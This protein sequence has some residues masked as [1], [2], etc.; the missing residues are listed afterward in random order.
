MPDGQ[1]VAQFAR[2]KVGRM[3]WLDGNA[4]LSTGDHM[5]LLKKDPVAYATIGDDAAMNCW[6][7]VFTL[8]YCASAGDSNAKAGARTRIVESDFFELDYAGVLRELLGFAGAPALN[9]DA[10]PGDVIFF[11]GM[12]HVGLSLGGNDV[13]SLWDTPNADTRLQATTI[14]ALDQAMKRHVLTYI[15]A[16]KQGLNDAGHERAQEIG[17]ALDDLREREEDHEGSVSVADVDAQVLDH[18]HLRGQPGFCIQRRA[19]PFAA[20]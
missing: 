12:S 19:N 10:A 6:E 3:T 1:T 15:S 9:D 2:G 13:V 7:A 14:A 4:A 11:Y 5:E 8:G 18:F 20:Y 16:L 17:D